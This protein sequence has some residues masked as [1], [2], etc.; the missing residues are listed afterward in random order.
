[1]RKVPFLQVPKSTGTHVITLV[2]R[3]KHFTVQNSRPRGRSHS[4]SIGFDGSVRMD[5][6][7]PASKRHLALASPPFLIAK[8]DVG[9]DDERSVGHDLG[10]KAIL[11]IVCRKRPAGDGLVPVRLSIGI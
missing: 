9:R 3:V 5:F 8:S 11:V 4:R 2:I 6:Q 10:A 7:R 1:T